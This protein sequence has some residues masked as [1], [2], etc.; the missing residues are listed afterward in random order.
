MT[1]TTSTQPRVLPSSRPLT[2]RRDRVDRPPRQAEQRRDE[3]RG[4]PDRTPMTAVAPSRTDDRL[5]DVRVPGRGGA[6]TDPTA[7]CCSITQAAV[8]A[9][10]GVRPVTQ[11]VQWL[12]PEVYETLLTRS[13]I[14]LAAGPSSSRP[15]RIRRARVH[16]VSERAAEATVIVDD[17]ERVR[18]AALRLEHHRGAWRVVAF[19]LG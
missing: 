4:R 2:A 18:A 16:R 5:P 11:L 12:A 10:R 7:L 8:E 19:V 15:A 1:I 13:R 6:P 9:L 3:P 14:T 17:L